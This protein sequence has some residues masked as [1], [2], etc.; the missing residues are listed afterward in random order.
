MSSNPIVRTIAKDDLEQAIALDS[1]ITGQSRRGFYRKRFAA[2]QDS[3]KGFLWLVAIV[4]DRLAGFVSA[5]LLEGEYGGIAP[6]AVID[7]VG[8]LPELRGW[9]RAW[10]SKARSSPISEGGFDEP[11]RSRFQRRLRR[12]FRGPV[13]R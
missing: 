8:V 10:C 1:R 12:R 2:M 4:D 6:S 13:P 3:P 5:H 7:A 11:V 9:R